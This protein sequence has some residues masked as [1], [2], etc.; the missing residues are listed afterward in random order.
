MQWTACNTA[1]LY[2]RCNG[3]ARTF[4]QGG[5]PLGRITPTAYYWSLF[6]NDDLRLEVWHK[7]YW[8]Y[9]IDIP[10][11]PLPEGVEIGDT[12]TAE[13]IDETAGNGILAVDPTTTK[14]WEGDGKGRLIDDAASYKNVIQF[15]YSE[16][17]LVA[18]EAYMR[19]GNTGRGQELFDQLR[20]RAG[21]GSIELNESNLLDEQARELGFEGRRYPMLK[22]LGLVLERIQTYSPEI[23]DI[24]L[25]THVRLPLPKDFV[26]LTGVPQNEGY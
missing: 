17:F 25:P 12:V 3:V 19:S 21:Q 2:D 26:D 23:G 5:R 13:N 9:D 6:Q 4:E 18:A 14:Y 8:V 7:R 11:D 10:E 16:A 24:M 22:R 1:P 15:R 20:A